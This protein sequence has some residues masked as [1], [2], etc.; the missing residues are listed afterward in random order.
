[1]RTSTKKAVTETL[2]LVVDDYVDSREMCA[3]YLALCGFRVEQAASGEEALAKSAAMRPDVILMDLTLPDIDGLEVTRRLKADTETSGIAIIALT[4]HA[5]GEHS[6]EAQ[7][8]GC[9]SF[10]VK[11]C[12]PDLMV[13][14]IKR[15]L[16]GPE[17][18]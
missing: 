1:M 16:A 8:A 11:P 18:P 5:M 2:V 17:A 6:A 12:H 3:E 9:V 15:V 4:G 7:E 10:L 14:E 13:E